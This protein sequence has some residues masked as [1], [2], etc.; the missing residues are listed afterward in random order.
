MIKWMGKYLVV[1]IEQEKIPE[2]LIESEHNQYKMG[3]ARV[4]F[5][6]DQKYCREMCNG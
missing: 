1:D 5:S 6:W 2:N 3:R 4:I